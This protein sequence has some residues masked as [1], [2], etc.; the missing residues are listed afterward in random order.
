MER[1]LEIVFHNVP[2]SSE[3]ETLIR[4]RMAKLEKFYPR[5]VSAR[6]AVEAPHKPHKSGNVPEVHVELHVPGQ[7]LVVRRD[8]G[9]KERHA[10]RDARAAVRDAF[11]AA[12]LKLQD[13]KR[14]QQRE[15][16]QHPSPLT[17][18]V[19]SL[20]VE[21]DYGFLTTNEGRELYFHANS[22]MDVAFA[23]LKNGDAVQFIEAEG[24]TG[25]L[26]SKVWRE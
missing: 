8:H 14:R 21:R 13:Y 5:I 1:P 3:I 9:T 4:E 12:T 25:P 11:E 17:A 20:F 6:V 15:V 24:D 23:D 16:K 10:V 26:A 22:V 18:R 7:T 2:P 19:T